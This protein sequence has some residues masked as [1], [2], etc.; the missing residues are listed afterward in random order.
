[1]SKSIHNEIINFCKEFYK[2]KA[3]FPTL[4]DLHENGITREVVRQ[5]FKTKSNLQKVVEEEMASA[6]LEAPK[7][8]TVSKFKKNQKKYVI[9]GVQNNTYIDQGLMKCLVQ[10]AKH[11]KAEILALPMYY[12][13]PT[14]ITESN[15]IEKE[16]WWDDNFPG[17]YV[18][19]NMNLGPHLKL[20]PEHRISVTAIN[21]LS[22]LESIGGKYSAIYSNSHLM[23]KVIPESQDKIPH[24]MQT[25]GTACKLDNFS[26]TNAGGKAKGFATRCALV[27]ELS[28]D[29]FHL[30]Q[31]EYKRGVVCDLDKVYTHT[32]VMDISDYGTSKMVW[33]DVH[34]EVADKVVV[35]VSKE[36]S[37]RCNVDCHYLEDVL[38]FIGQNHHN[39]KNV[40]MK[41]MLNKHGKDIVSAAI[42]QV[43][44]FILDLTDRASVKIVDSNHHDHITKWINEC[45]FKYMEADNAY[46]YICLMKKIMEEVVLD[47][48]QLTLSNDNVLRMALELVGGDS[49][50]DVEFLSR[51]ESHTVS[52]IELSQHGDKGPNGSRGS[53]TALSRT[54][55]PMVIGH[56]HTP[57][58]HKH[59]YQV[60]KTAY[61]NQSYTQ[62]YSSHLHSHCIIYPNGGRTLIHILGGQYRI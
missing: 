21:P 43:A 57:G 4:S 1:M 22:G 32:D 45:N 34:A 36:L 23:M 46:F 14:N 5:N 25:T 54:N 24:I 42:K 52:G 31:L 19:K 62:G 35:R 26:K 10:Y 58:I 50:A 27:V 60:G 6:Y 8:N 12:R 7:E 56:S 13:N 33:G 30:R 39:R 18:T 16:Y 17:K 44:Q 59:I 51:N 55:S 41:Y 15:R 37:D 61:K 48:Q 49:A 47:E 28:G 38:D 53:I 9:I 11:N 2:L 29:I 3:R 20:M 40:I